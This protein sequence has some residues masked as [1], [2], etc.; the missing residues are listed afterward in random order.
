MSKLKRQSGF[1]FLEQVTAISVFAVTSATA[2]QYMDQWADTSEQHV[3]QYSQ[4]AA[5]SAMMIHQQWDQAKGISSSVKW[6]TVI[7]IQGIE[8]VV[9]SESLALTSPSGKHCALLNLQSG[10]VVI[11]KG[12]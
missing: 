9:T 3:L 12:C 4:V 8:T 5:E 11:Q 7:D 2:A 1:T 10:K 6:D